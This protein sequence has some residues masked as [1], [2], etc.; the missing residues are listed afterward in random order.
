MPS[1]EVAAAGLCKHE[2]LSRRDGC[3][4]PFSRSTSSLIALACF[5]C[6][7][8]LNSVEWTKLIWGRMLEKSQVRS[9]CLNGGQACVGLGSI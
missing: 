8:H 2:A 3:V 5:N 9:V 7:I 4:N 1:R 6:R